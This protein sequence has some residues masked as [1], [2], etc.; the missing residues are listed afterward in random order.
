MDQQ[1]LEVETVTDADI[2]QAWMEAK[3]N[4]VKALSKRLA[5]IYSMKEP[6]VI[7]SGCGDFAKR[8]CGDWRELLIALRALG[9]LRLQLRNELLSHQITGLLDPMSTLDRHLYFSARENSLSLDTTSLQLG[10]LV[11]EPN[12]N[13][14][15]AIYFF[16]LDGSP[17][18]TIDISEEA[19]GTSHLFFSRFFHPNQTQDQPVIQIKTKRTEAEWPAR[20]I[21]QLRQEWSNLISTEEIQPFL[22]KNDISYQQLLNQLG[23]H[24]A[25]PLPK[26]SLRILLEVGMDHLIPFR[27]I[28]YSSGSVMNWCGEVTDIKTDNETLYAKGLD[29][30]LSFE[31]EAVVQGWLVTIPG[32]D[33]PSRAEFFDHRGTHLITL[34]LPHRVKK[35]FDHS[36]REIVEILVTLETE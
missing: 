35:R 4:Q 20:E 28:S 27:I 5:D 36:W 13:H 18:L 6:Q 1:I 16:D 3:P 14:Y 21:E 7:A 10:Y 26:G 19:R 8:L 30:T 24:L 29:M 22:D 25:R 34:T 33:T 2:R 12:H 17:V 15:N 23:S 11:K 31:E 9:P 32:A